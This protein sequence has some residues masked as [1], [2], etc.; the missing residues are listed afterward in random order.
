MPGLRNVRRVAV[1]AEPRARWRFAV[2]SR[3]RR[4]DG[5]CTVGM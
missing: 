2:R 3:P 4:A 5:V 1:N